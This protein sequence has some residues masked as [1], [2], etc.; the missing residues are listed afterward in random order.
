M[1]LDP[2]EGL[3]LKLEHLRQVLTRVGGIDRAADRTIR[4]PLPLAYRGRVRFALDLRGRRPRLG[5]RPSGSRDEVVAVERCFLAPA[6]ATELAH[7]VLDRWWR[8]GSQGRAPSAPTH[9]EIRHSRAEDRYLAV[10]HTPPGP[11][12]GLLAA[13][14]RT[15]GRLEDLVGVCR[16]VTGKGGATGLTVLAGRDRLRERIGGFEVDY[17][18]T[19]FLQVNALCAAQLYRQ[20]AVGLAIG[21]RAP[22]RLLDLYCGAGLIALHAGTEATECLGVEVDGTSI[23]GAENAARRAGR[24][25]FRFLRSD[26]EPVLEQ[27]IARGE[28]YEAVAL[29]PPR[30]GAAEPVPR[31][32]RRL[33]ARRVVVVSC[34][35]AA[36]ARDLRRLSSEGF[37]LTDLTAVD[38]FP[39]TA[40][41][42]V[43][44][45]LKRKGG[46]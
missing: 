12:R 33:G 6:R 45:S 7:M 46:A 17:L 42:E 34:H 29:N 22:R 1:V 9:L 13:A 19:G 41:L 36:L 27:L 5:Y 32:I 26:V 40:H 31:A 20:A 2:A 18:A 30:Q 4:S 25:R 21:G 37:E 28:T 3:R 43:V 24:P 38:M 14:E 44:A 39:Q 11:A 15:L 8:L 35:P 23:R 10:W 16:V